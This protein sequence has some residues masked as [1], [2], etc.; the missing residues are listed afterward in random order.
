M[1]KTGLRK[2]TPVFSVLLHNYQAHHLIPG[3]PVSLLLD[4]SFWALAA[5]SQG[6]HH[7]AVLHGQA[8][9]SGGL[10][11]VHAKHTAQVPVQV[12]GVQG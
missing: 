7:Q 2:Y 9:L 4:A 3:Q 11:R 1:F 10:L 12:G 6:L 8:Q 5:N